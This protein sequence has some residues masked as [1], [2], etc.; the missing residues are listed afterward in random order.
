M[1]AYPEVYCPDYGIPQHRRRLVLFASKYGQIKLEA[2]THT[3]EKYTTVREAIYGFEELKAGQTSKTDPLHKASS[4]SE[5]NLRRIRASVPGGTWRDWPDEL[6]AECHRKKSGDG[7]ASVYGRMAWDEPSP[8]ITTQCYGF[9][10]GRFGHPEQD[11]AISLRETA[12]LQTFPKDYKFV[13]P[14]TPHHI[15]AIGK[16]IGNAVPVE[17]ARVIARKYQASLESTL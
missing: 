12:L 3:P 15:R 14:E 1:T 9:G 7:Y 8:T 4:L 13:P 2:K 16:F 10:S 5:L 6:V 11:R 17:L